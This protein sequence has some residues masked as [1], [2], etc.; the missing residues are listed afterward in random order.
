MMA[1]VLALIILLIFSAL[2][3]AA[4]TSLTSL[5]D[6][7]IAGLQKEKNKAAGRLAK[8]TKAPNKFLGAILVGNTFTN[9]VTSSLTVII[10]TNFWGQNAVVFST[11]ALTLFVL[12]FCEVSP[13]QIAYAHNEK[14]AKFVSLL[15]LP[16]TIIFAPL[17]WFI[18][19]FAQLINRLFG[20]KKRVFAR[21]NIFHLINVGE[22]S[23]EV[24]TYQKEVVHN[25]FRLAGSTAS[26]IMTHRK[27]VFSLPATLTVAEALPKVISEG[28]S[29]IPVYN[30]SSENII[31]I[32]MQ[33]DVYQRY[34]ADE[35]T[36]LLADFMLA[37]LFVPA[38]MRLDELLKVFK[39]HLLNIAIVLD[40]YG[41]LAG[42]VSRE[43]VLEE[44]LGELYDENEEAELKTERLDDGSW[45][46]QGDTPLH[47]LEQQL[48]HNIGGNK[49]VNTIS[50]H[51]IEALD[52]L[53]VDGEVVD[54]PGEGRFKIETMQNN[55]II[56]LRFY[57]T[58]TEDNL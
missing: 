13:K 26:A 19:L 24:A 51:I 58:S 49:H 48:G 17:I 21:E 14:T 56:S 32:V 18:S 4:E 20:D 29:R 25:I 16:M 5:S 8:L 35:E 37:P 2:F 46:L 55:R 31:G 1:L 3:S 34:S 42:I 50:G 54:I 33:R 15:I 10:V 9:V 41:G 22:K 40:E 39:N 6:L 12:I 36:T 43:D 7:Q 47:W 28:Y 52:K 57:P 45:R 23:G 38:S 30:E 27:D 44:I 53:P 11:I